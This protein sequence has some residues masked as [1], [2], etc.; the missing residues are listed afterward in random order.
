MTATS[1]ECTKRK[2]IQVLRAE[3]AEFAGVA[4]ALEQAEAPSDVLSALHP[5]EKTH[6]CGQMNALGGSLSVLALMA[7]EHQ[8]RTP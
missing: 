5:L 2:L 1:V 4:A 6:L 3:A 8:P 7:Q